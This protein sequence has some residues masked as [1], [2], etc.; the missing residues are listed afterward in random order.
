MPAIPVIGAVGSAIGSAVAAVGAGVSAVGATVASAVGLGTVSTVAATAIGSGVLSGGITA[1]QGGDIS[2]VLESAV[3]GGVTSFVGGTV[4]NAVGSTVSNLTGST[5]AGSTVGNVAGALAA[6]GSSEDA[7]R[8]GLIGGAI[9][10]LNSAEDI[11]NQQKF[12]N[13]ML[14]SGLAGQ[15]LMDDVDNLLIDTQP[16][17]SLDIP[18]TKDAVNLF[19]VARGLAPSVVTALLQKSAYDNA[20]INDQGQTLYS[21]IAPP[22]DWKSPDYTQQQAPLPTVEPVDFG[23]VD[24]LKGTQW[25]QTAKPMQIDGLMSVLNEQYAQPQT[26][27]QFGLDQIVGNV[28]DVPMSINDIINSIGNYQTQPFDMNQQI[29]QIDGSPVSLASI[30]AGIQSQ[31]G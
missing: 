11:F 2:D 21:I 30:I 23:S 7:L 14:E 22:S 12:E 3:K 29:G 13:S 9:S 5:I 20:T 25:D 16:V 19:G 6:G 8:S 28:N 31:Y 24:L 1:L 26:M 18:S 27:A 15:T 4:A 17:G 10:G